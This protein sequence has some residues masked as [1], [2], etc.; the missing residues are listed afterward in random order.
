M[1]LVKV[2]KAY[3]KPEIGEAILEDNLMDQN[4]ASWVVTGEDE[5]GE[6]VPIGGSDDDETPEDAKPFVFESDW[7]NW[8]FDLEN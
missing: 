8:Q 1:V 3:I 5:T 7:A 6:I 2:K 4:F